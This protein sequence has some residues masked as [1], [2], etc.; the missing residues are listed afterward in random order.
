[1][2]DEI[3]ILY[4]IS[5]NFDEMG[6]NQIYMKEQ[7]TD[8][9]KIEKFKINFRYCHVAISK[10]GGLMAIC[11][12]KGFLDMS[13]GA[14]LNRSIVVMFQ[15]FKKRYYV[16][17]NWDYNKRDIVC[18]DFTPKEEL[19]AIISD[20]GIFK[21]NYYERKHKEISTSQYLQE[22]ILKAKF[23]GKGFIAYTKFSNFY[24]VKDIK[25]PVPI[26]MASF[27]GIMDFIPE[28]LDFV[29]ISP[30]YSS[31]KKF[32]LLITRQDLYG[33]VIQ[34]IEKEEGSNTQVNPYGDKFT[35]IIGGSSIIREK[36]QKLL[37]LNKSVIEQHIKKEEEKK[38]RLEKGKEIK[39]DK[40]QEVFPPELPEPQGEQGEMGVIS[41]IAISPSGEKIA[42]Y[43]KY[44]KSAFLMKTDFTEQYKEIHFEYDKSNYSDLEQKEIDDALDFQEGCQF[45]FCGEDTLAIS[46]QRYIILTKPNMPNALI[47]LIFEGGQSEIKHGSLFSKCITETDG[48]R[49][50]TNEGVFLINK[51]PKELFDLC[52]P[53]SKSPSKKLVQI[54]KNTILRKYNSDKDIRSLSTVLAD[55]IEN[56]QIAC[57]NIYWTDELNNDF[58]KEVQLFTLKAAQYAKKFVNKDE[59]NFDK[60]NEICK[61]M[62][63]INNLRNNKDTPV[64]ITF[65]EYKQTSSKEIISKLIKYK[66][67]KLAADISKFLEYGTKK[68]LHKYVIA[69]MKREIKNIEKALDIQEESKGKEM[70]DEKSKEM[71]EKYRTLFYHLEKVPGMSYIKLAK[72]ASK[73]GGK[74][75][76]KYLIEQERSALIK[77]PQLLQFDN[78]KYDEPLRIA[79]E[80]YDFNAVI[81]V[82]N[83]IIK[84]GRFNILT[85]MSYQKYFP[86]LLLYLKKYDKEAVINFLDLT[87]N[88]T[89]LFYIQLNRYFEEK[90]GDKREQEIKICRSAYKQVDN[91]PNFDGKFIKKYLEKLEKSIKFKKECQTPDKDIIHYSEIEPYSVSIYDCYKSGFMKGKANWIESEN[92]NFD[93]SNK[94]LNLLK[95]RS[96][97]ELKRPDAIES[98][99]QK[100]SLKKMGLTPMHL[101][102]MFFDY[103][104]YDKAAE[105][106]MQVK[107]PFYFSYVIDILKSME[108]YKEALEYII[109]SK[110]I[111]EKAIMVNEILRKQPKLEKFVND[112]CEKYKV[113]LQ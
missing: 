108:K 97:L 94:K 19:Y 67:F 63:I 21:I 100:T 26:L 78:K 73:Y 103:K 85:D 79:F 51:V 13:R 65:R 29:G 61:D 54:Y 59:F 101:G 77:I 53:F 36:P 40:N 64:F 16:P 71:K 111:D 28:T 58:Q 92:K 15:D 12:K 9:H 45:L 25:N 11:K 1:M 23:Y 62:R 75:L 109:A 48:L 106:L 90:I 110:D 33:G 96:Y 102:E 74:N 27:F 76:S 4:N 93:Y 41:A 20:G 17:I 49:F 43:N 18:L 88:N 91:D 89:E 47:Y 22:G 55:S 14:V 24:Y 31:S 70:E 60:F 5:N 10:N 35:E 46:R 3:E 30:D 72:K 8:F 81:K 95:L 44:K 107:D 38:K 104:Y 52:H 105:Y 39:E 7:I 2:L 37:M 98:Q 80:T 57:A 6:K 66:N 69:I 86:K 34:L 68:V 84:E 83:K 87:K 56:L 112:L 99:L 32:E 50:L 42:F 113:S 82:I